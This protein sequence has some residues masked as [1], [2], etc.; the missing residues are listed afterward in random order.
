MGEKFSVL[1]MRDD[2]QVKRFRIHPNWFRVILFVFFLLAV[3]SVGGLYFSWTFWHDNIELTG[4]VQQL[5]HRVQQ[6]EVKL[7]SLENMERILE[8]HDPEELQMLIASAA[9]PQPASELSDVVDLKDIFKSVEGKGAT[10]EDVA[11][12]TLDEGGY[13]LRF[14]LK[15]LDKGDENLTG[16]IE[17]SLISRDGHLLELKFPIDE[18]SFHIQRFRTFSSVFSLPR[19]LV[20]NDVYALRLQV[21]A[22]DGEV[23]YSK[24]YP[25]G[26]IQTS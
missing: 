16:Y 15:N 14:V 5:Q 12:E 1:L 17:A 9:T 21:I 4:E 6:Q 23:V 18:M 25:A 2:L 10:L 8:L 26:S 13:R 7:T 3:V 11:L 24:T 20:I 19:G 22:E